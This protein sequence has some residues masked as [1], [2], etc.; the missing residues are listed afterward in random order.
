VASAAAVGRRRAAG[1]GTDSGHDGG[2]HSC[3]ELVRDAPLGS[4]D[5]DDCD[6]GGGGGW[7]SDVGS[8]VPLKLLIRPAL[9]FPCRRFRRC[10]PR[11]WR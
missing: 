9:G 5:G 6:S 2:R 3:P 1:A 8:V 10:G 4:D 11:C 7:E